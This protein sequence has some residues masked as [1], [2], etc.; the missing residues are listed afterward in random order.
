MYSS[1]SL[2]YL[3]TPIK[4]FKIPPNKNPDATEETPMNNPINN[5]AMPVITKTMK[6]F[7]L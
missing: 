6:T 3:T 7:L 4:R 1:I 5:D 2:Q